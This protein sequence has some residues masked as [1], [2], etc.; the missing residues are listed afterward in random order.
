VSE[1]MLRESSRAQRLNQS[2]WNTNY[3]ANL[4][5]GARYF[6]MMLHQYQMPLSQA[7]A[8]YKAGPNG[9][10]DSDA[11]KK[12]Q[13]RFNTKSATLQKLVHCMH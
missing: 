1:R 10:L 9:D 13:G 2:G 11:A 7:A 3:V 12:Y 6:R 8:A 4:E 5:A